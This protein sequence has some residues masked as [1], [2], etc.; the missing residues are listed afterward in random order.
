ML[1]TAMAPTQTNKPTAS[2]PSQMAPDIVALVLLVLIPILC[3]V[4][5]AVKVNGLRELL[6]HT[7]TTHTGT[8]QRP[9][10]APSFDSQHPEEPQ[11]PR[12]AHILPAQ[13]SR[14]SSDNS[15]R[16]IAAT[17]EPSPSPPS[18][19]AQ[20]SSP[21]P[22]YN[23]IAPSQPTATATSP[24][25]SPPAYSTS[26]QAQSAPLPSSRTS[27][28][29]LSTLNDAQPDYFPHSEQEQTHELVESGAQFSEH[30]TATQNLAD[31]IGSLSPPSPPPPAS[32]PAHP[33]HHA[34]S[35]AA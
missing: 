5:L 4:I 29:S 26:T 27:S 33:T 2:P 34:A 21:P 6:G 25:T 8:A 20:R 30:N 19:P 23:H 28:S 12:R 31:S 16:V 24:S 1:T 18:L 14:R 32:P 35:P 11:A 22:P 10:P 7:T 9:S 3:L 15:G 13:Q 17:D